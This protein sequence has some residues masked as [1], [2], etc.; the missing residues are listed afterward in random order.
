MKKTTIIVMFITVISKV[1]GFIRDIVL[2][3][4]FGASEITDAFKAAINVPNIVLSVIIAAFVT[5]IV[6]MLTRISKEDHKRGDLFVNNIMNILLLAALLLVIAIQIV[7]ELFMV[8]FGGAGFGPETMALAAMFLRMISFGVFAII[9]VQLGTGYLNVKGSFVAP[10]LVGIP[11]NFLV[12]IGLFVAAR[13]NR[14]DL[15]IIAQLL[16]FFSQGLI[17]FYFMRKRGYAYTAYIDFKD[18]DLKV[19]LN[20]SLPLVIASF[21]GQFNAVMMKNFATQIYGVGA[22]TLTDM[23]EKLIGF[24]QGIFIATI[25][26]I[27]YPTITRS[28]VDH[29]DEK[30]VYGFNE[31]L[32][33]ISLFVLPAMIGFLVLPREILSFVYARGKIT[34]DDIS[35]LVPI[36]VAWTFAI[37]PQALRDLLSRMHYAYQDMKGPVINTVIFSI[38]YVSLMFFGG[39]YFS[40]YGQGLTALAAALAIANLIAAYP[41]YR[42]MKKHLPS[43]NIRKIVPDLRKLSMA[44]LAMGLTVLL[45]KPLLIHFVSANLALILLIMI[46]MLVYL[47]LLWVL[48]V[49]FFLNL[50]NSFLKKA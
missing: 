21:L 19:M 17:I 26:N 34:G 5:G 8:A 15:M 48:K 36:F 31:A 30:V 9:V 23:V 32:L 3:S 28:V 24:V 11:A 16:G 39:H 2:T 20:L 49:Q 46:G 4:L 12:I 27:T 40:Q 42:S 47:A 43:I 14:E 33:L 7:P 41:L 44:A 6:P 35:V 10:A 25:L 22:Y 50:I 38:I 18:H 13:M 29:N 45:L 1:L 37:F